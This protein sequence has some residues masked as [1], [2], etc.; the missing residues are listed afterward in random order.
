M[1][2]FMQNKEDGEL[3][4][5]D[6]LDRFSYDEKFEIEL[7]KDRFRYLYHVENK[8]FVPVPEGVYSEMYE[9]CRT[10]LVHPDDAGYEEL[11]DP[12]TLAG[13]LEEAKECGFVMAEFREKMVDGT[14]KWVRYLGI[15]GEEHG[16]PAGKIYFYVFD[17]QTHRDRME[18]HAVNLQD[19]EQR[20]PATGLRKREMFVPAVIEKMPDCKGTWCCVAI[21]IQH[22]KIFNSWFGYDK[23][24]YLLSR[25]G[26]YLT[27]FEERENAVAASFGRDNF[28]VFLAYNE[29]KIEE[30]Y[31]AIKEFIFSYTNM[32]G[33]LPALGVFIMPEGTRPGYETYDKARIAV[34]DAKKSYINRIC[35]YNSSKYEET[36]NNFQFLTEFQSAMENREITFFIQPQCSI[37]DGRIVGGEAL[38]R[39]TTGDGRVINPGQFVPFL[40]SSGFITELDKY[41]WD[42]V[43]RWIRSLLDR[44]ITPLPISVNV[45]QIDLLT[46]DVAACLYSLTQ[47]Y[48]IPPKYLKVEITESAYAENFDTVSK[49]I[50]ELKKYGFLVYL[51]DFGS[52]YSSLNM[53]DRINVDLIKLDMLFMKKENSLGKK[54]IGIVES[55]FGMTK[56]LELPVIVE[57]VE[58]DDQIRFLQNLGFKYAQGYYFYRPISV[59]E[60]EKLLSD[61]T[62]I[63]RSGLQKATSDLIRAREFLQENMFTESTLNR[64]LGAVAFYSLVDEN[65]TITR[66]NEPF[67]IAIGDAKMDSRIQNIQ[68]YVVE[69]DRPAMYQ[70][71]RKAE[72]NNTEGGKCEVRFIKSDGSVFWFRMQF[73]YLKSE[74][75]KKMFFGQVED[76]TEQREQS[77]HFFDVLRKQSDVTMCIELDRNKIQYVTGDNTLYQVD[78]P[79]M[80]LDRSV[81]QTA[82][83][84]IGNEADRKAFLDFFD[85]NR[86]RDA[87][88]KAI[89]HEVL[90][91]DFVLTNKPEPVEFSTYY[92]RHNRDDSLIVYAF[93]KK[94][95]REI[96]SL[97]PMT[98][99]KNRYAYNETVEMLIAHGRTEHELIV[100]SID[101]NGL[102][103]TNDTYGH[104]AGDEL[105]KTAA[106]AIG[107]VMSPYGGGF[108]TGGDEFAAFVYGRKELAAFLKEELNRALAARSEKLGRSITVSCGYAT[109]EEFPGADINELIKLADLRMY[110]AKSKF[111]QTLEADR[112]SQQIAFSA[113]CDSYTKILKVNLTKDSYEI[114]RAEENELN[115]ARGY[116]DSFSG[117]MKDF[118][119]TGQVHPEDEEYFKKNVS[120]EYLKQYFASGVKEFS[121]NYRRRINDRFSRVMLEIIPAPDYSDL[122]QKV[123]LYVKDI[124]GLIIK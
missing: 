10:C 68:N 38:A 12:V 110:R 28:A 118:A 71:L 30:L 44:N 105:I 8:F 45:S 96:L 60:F 116:A 43:C 103:N 24:Y 62:C 27:E 6:F 18:G 100:F 86:L 37:L 121:I 61:E 46:I 119:R 102:K 83:H 26:K 88:K 108:R 94:R 106:E 90:N 11:L 122:D 14:Y 114:I 117:W 123:F 104:S 49:T 9:Y 4:T 70:A 21:D 39:W 107:E 91:I 65:V 120:P 57:G 109:R 79:S 16:V 48:H 3:T 33:F 93:A 97:D 19:T 22:F 47:H 80:D 72:E 54:G 7:R 77:L 55:I 82:V 53:L 2:I 50:E 124:G 81:Y 84:R 40:E 13:K 31:N 20:D 89:Y 29:S 17:I 15:T 69:Q 67:R 112:R 52:G 75:A 74:G 95:D 73:F 64:I 78:L 76:I 58:N 85:N 101:V 51:D 63:D 35:Y 66:F 23:G 36:K 98:G 56:A 115:A 25:I 32:L 41:V 87:Y 34:E 113:L 1:N 99:M 92:I 42:C 5:A 111:Y 59:Q